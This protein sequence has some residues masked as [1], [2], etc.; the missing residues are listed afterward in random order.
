M[1][2][3]LTDPPT[4]PLPPPQQPQ[5]RHVPTPMV[6]VYERQQWEYKVIV[7]GAISEGELNALGA[8][9]W[10]LAGVTSLRDTLQFYF[11]RART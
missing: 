8:D 1:Q 11:K 6:Y 9:G 7:Q 2:S 4:H 5:R 3:Q 10:E